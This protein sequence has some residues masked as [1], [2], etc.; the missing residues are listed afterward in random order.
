[1]AGVYIF[2]SV[3][4][5]QCFKRLKTVLVVNLIILSF[6]S[7]SS[8][9]TYVKNR[10]NYRNNHATYRQREIYTNIH[11]TKYLRE[12]SHPRNEHSVDTSCQNPW[13]K[14]ALLFSSFTEGLQKSPRSRNFLK[15]SL[16]LSILTEYA[17]LK[18]P[19]FQTPGSIPRDDF[20]EGI[21]AL[22]QSDDARLEETWEEF[23]R[24]DNAILRFV[25][26][27]TAMYALRKESSRSPGK[28]RQ[29][30]RADG[31]KRRDKIVEEVEKMLDGV[32]V[33]AIT[34]DLSDGS[35]KQPAGSKNDAL[36]P[37]TG[38]EALKNWNPHLIY[39]EGGNT[40]WLH[41]CIE[42][43]MW[44]NDLRSAIT[45]PNAA[46]YCGKS[47]GAIIAGKRV[48]TAC[49]KEW[50]DPSVVQG[51]E[52]YQDWNGVNGLSLAGNFSFFP[53]MNE[54]W[55]ELK[56]DNQDVLCLKDNEVCCIEGV[57]Q[58]ISWR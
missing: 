50:D 28:Q 51:R 32:E 45:G 23:V 35:V 44:S 20:V 13:A 2:L 54:Q 53:H 46:V 10:P 43:G 58:T 47:A 26:V 56:N 27:P 1:M 33:F 57:E 17:T 24:E 36:Y 19:T 34:L 21:Q 38:K 12:S 8:S 55:K 41:N 48:D 30:A 39:V 7:K 15:S 3:L 16:A 42:N 37:K 5:M 14:R 31:K 11:T 52:T 9:F 29:R 22:E 25:Y 40:F 18:E 49:W 6:C 4:A